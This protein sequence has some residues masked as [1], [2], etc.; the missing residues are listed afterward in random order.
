MNSSKSW[1]SFETKEYHKWYRYTNTYTYF[2]KK[3]QAVWVKT[4][5][6]KMFIWLFQP[7][8]I[9]PW[10]AK[11]GTWEYPGEK[12]QRKCRIQVPRGLPFLALNARLATRE[13]QF[14]LFV[15]ESSL[16]MV[17]VS[18]HCIHRWGGLEDTL[19]VVN[20]SKPRQN[21]WYLAEKIFKFSS[22]K[23]FE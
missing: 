9:Y 5:E 10:H 3:S 11:P 2:S 18:A 16:T 19:I 12:C 22:L 20:T 7:S 17:K 21:G 13:I 14:A 15:Q 6:K 23:M 1:F 4:Q 8:R